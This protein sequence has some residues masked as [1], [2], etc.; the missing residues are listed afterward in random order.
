MI[1]LVLA[2]LAIAGATSAG[3][4]EQLC[5]QAWG[6]I[7]L[8]WAACNVVGA[9]EFVFNTYV[10]IGAAV[11]VSSLGT[12]CFAYGHLAPAHLPPIATRLSNGSIIDMPGDR[13]Y[14]HTIPAA[15][16]TK[17]H[18]P[19]TTHIVWPDIDLDVDH[20]FLKNIG[21][22][23]GQTHCTGNAQK[24]LAGSNA[25][26]TCSNRAWKMVQACGRGTR[27]APHPLVKETRVVCEP[28]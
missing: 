5:R 28:I 14:H 23:A 27:C 4:S 9:S 19:S 7:G 10:C 16:Y 26:L 13:V 17:R 12:L 22:A 3:P 1:L 18:L 2:S 20:Q 8:S 24:C 21:E 15:V 6:I 25:I 11:S